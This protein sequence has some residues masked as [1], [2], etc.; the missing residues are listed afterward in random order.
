MSILSSVQTL[1]NKWGRTNSTPQNT[2]HYRKIYNPPEKSRAES[3]CRHTAH[4]EFG[5]VGGIQENKDTIQ[6]QTLRKNQEQA[7]DFARSL[8]DIQDS[9]RNEPRQQSYLHT[10]SIDNCCTVRLKFHKRHILRSP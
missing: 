9:G 1:T 5:Y 2:D 3:A 10:C 8:L 4:I 7:R 6:I